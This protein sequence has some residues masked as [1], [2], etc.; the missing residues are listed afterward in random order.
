MHV[1]RQL[2]CVVVSPAAAVIMR[3]AP[4]AVDRTGIDRSW[5]GLLQPDG[6]RLPLVTGSRWMAMTGWQL[7]S[8][9]C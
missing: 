1:A 9:R 7:V 4:R 5:V 3:I 8:R 6:Q 2:I